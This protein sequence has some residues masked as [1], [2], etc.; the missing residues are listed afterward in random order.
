MVKKKAI[1]E[2]K[3]LIFCFLVGITC[4]LVFWL[5]LL[6]LSAGTK[7]IWNVIPGQEPAA[8]YPL[9]AC[10]A[11]AL[12]I[13]ILRKHCGDYPEGMMVVFG[14]IK[15]NGAYPYRNMLVII[16]SALLPLIFGFSVGPEAGMVGIIAALCSWAGENL[17]FAGAEASWYSRMGTE[18]SLSILFR[19]PLF[20]IFD[21]EEDADEREAEA[22]A[23]T[24]PMK[25]TT[26]CIAAG[27]GFAC[28]ALLNQLHR[29]SEGFPSFDSITLGKADYILF[30]LYLVCGVLLGLFFEYSE[31]IM[32]RYAG[33][34][35][36]VISE[37][38]AG[39]VMGGIACFLPVIRFSGEEQMGILISDYAKYAPIAM[40]GIAFL[41]II[42]TT[43]CIN[44]GL[45]GGHFFPL[46]FSAV[47]LGYGLSLTFFSQDASHA[48]F[49]AA[50]VCAGTLGVSLKKPL[51]VSALLLLCFPVK[52]L[53]WIVPSA[54]A[55]AWAGNLAAGMS[56][57]D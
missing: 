12:L 46:I 33:F 20:G 36:P 2:G 50:V 34:L 16:V 15:K 24:R 14:K 27:G 38:I 39:A 6:V 18:L 11:G 3:L 30:V 22:G 35:P 55:A 8:W 7:L 1:N 56:R 40:I 43:M 57:K 10:T 13:G 31:R 23:I 37:L 51:A 48:V 53:L 28:F 26:Y 4:G 9:A 19:S 47:C 45:K 21:V 17:R 25:I 5:F 41:K 32:H 52:A 54:A 49:A 29:V 42:L 44:L